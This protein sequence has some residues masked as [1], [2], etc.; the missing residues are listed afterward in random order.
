MELIVTEGSYFV[1]LD[2]IK[3]REVNEEFIGNGEMR[4]AFTI[5]SFA[6]TAHLV[7]LDVDGRTK[8]ILEMGCVDEI[9]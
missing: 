8:Y 5:E 9:C 2:Y 1:V 7:Y 3:E 4:N 6:A